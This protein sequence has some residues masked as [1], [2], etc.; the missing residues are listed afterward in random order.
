[1]IPPYNLKEKEKMDI[2]QKYLLIGLNYIAIAVVTF[3]LFYLRFKQFMVLI[4]GILVGVML[5]C[6]FLLIE[7]YTQRGRE[8]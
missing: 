8:W 4:S 1:M 7:F 3:A 5:M 6:G 2:Y